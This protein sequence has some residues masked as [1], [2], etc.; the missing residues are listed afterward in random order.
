MFIGIWLT[1][2]CNLKCRY[3]YNADNIGKNQDLNSEEW[4]KM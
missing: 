3:C 1:T 4:K 2:A